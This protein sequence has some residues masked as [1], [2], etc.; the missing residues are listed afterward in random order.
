MDC[1]AVGCDVVHCV[2]CGAGTD[3]TGLCGK[4]N[5]EEESMGTYDGAVKQT[6]AVVLTTI[7]KN[8]DALEADDWEDT[9]RE[10]R[11]WARTARKLALILLDQTGYTMARERNA[12]GTP[13]E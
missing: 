5:Y 3:G 10:E 4:H 1:G 9:T 12:D 13:R 2:I 11:E 8:V 6:D 7:I